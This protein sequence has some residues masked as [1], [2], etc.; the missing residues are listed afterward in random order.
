MLR[1]KNN[2]TAGQL[3]LQK[4][5]PPPPRTYHRKVY[6]YL[7]LRICHHCLNKIVKWNQNMLYQKCQVICRSFRSFF[8]QTERKGM[9]YF[10]ELPFLCPTQ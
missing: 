4:L 7:I 9:V 10:S 6:F 8:T 2:C 5:P 1:I 3:K